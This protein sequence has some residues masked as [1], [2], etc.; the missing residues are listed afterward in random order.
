MTG[1]TRRIVR[2]FSNSAV[3]P[4]VA[5]FVLTFTHTRVVCAVFDITIHVQPLFSHCEW[6][7][8]RPA[9]APGRLPC[10]ENGEE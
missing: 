7:L 2:L 1:M 9:P 4:V 6:G 8:P 3:A 10:G 5:F